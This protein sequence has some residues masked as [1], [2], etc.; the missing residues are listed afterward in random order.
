MYH[1]KQVKINKSND[2]SMKVCLYE[3]FKEH[4]KTEHTKK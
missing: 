3:I 2:Q 4:N 1:E